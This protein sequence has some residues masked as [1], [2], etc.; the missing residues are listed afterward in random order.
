MEAI[1]KIVTVRNNILKVSLPDHYN[2]KPVEIIILPAGVEVA[3]SYVGEAEA[4]YER[5]E[6][7]FNYK[8]LFGS[9]NS[10]LS[11]HQIDQQLKSLR[12]EWES[13]IS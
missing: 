6:V 7:E 13:D 8:E 2:N 1:R 12:D 10:G 9:L 11:A 3:S 5:Q 4:A